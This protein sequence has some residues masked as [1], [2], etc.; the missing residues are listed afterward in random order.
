MPARVCVEGVRRVR[1][2]IYVK[3]IGEKNGRSVVVL[4]SRRRS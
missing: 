4:K 2:G 1:G 3:Y